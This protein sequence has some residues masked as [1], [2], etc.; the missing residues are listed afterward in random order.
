MKRWAIIAV[1]LFLAT[2]ARAEVPEQYR[3]LLMKVY[4][5]QALRASS[6]D[7]QAAGITKNLRQ[8]DED[9]PNVEKQRLVKSR[10]EQIAALKKTVAQLRAHEIV[11]WPEVSFLTQ[12]A[13]GK[14]PSGIRHPVAIRVSG[15]AV[16]AEFSYTVNELVSDGGNSRF[17]TRG[18]TRPVDKTSTFTI[19]YLQPQKYL[20]GES[21]KLPDLIEMSAP[22]PNATLTELDWDHASP[23]WQEFVKSMAP[24]AKAK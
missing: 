21:I 9:T 10:Q 7:A 6:L 20:L 3:E 17:T 15:S 22:G 8:F 24:P 23:F 12:G 11:D 1:I 19:K 18:F 16:V 2:A 14:S 4:N 5:A 13:I